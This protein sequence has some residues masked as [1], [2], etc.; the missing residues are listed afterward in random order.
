MD[1]LKIGLLMELKKNYCSKKRKVFETVES[2]EWDF[3]DEV[4]V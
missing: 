3:L 4:E 2:N 1:T